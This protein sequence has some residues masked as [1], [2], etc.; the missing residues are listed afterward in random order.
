MVRHRYLATCPTGV[1]IYL[2]QE[3]AQL[4]A[5]AVVEMPAGV[6]FEGGLSLAYRVCLWSRLAN[7]VLLQLGTMQA[8]S[9]D[10]LY[11]A[12]SG[13]DWGAHIPPSGSLAVDFSGR[14]SGV[15]NE[16]FGAQ[17]L[18]DAIVDQFRTKGLSRPTV[19]L[20]APDVRV[21]ARLHKGA[22][23]LAIDLSGDSLHRRGYRLDGG[24]APLKENIAAAAL[25]AAGWSS[26]RAQDQALIDP[27]CGSSTLLLEGALMALDRAPGL[28]RERFGFNGWGGHDEGQWRAIFSEANERARAGAGTSVEIRGYDGDIQAVR[29]S[30]HNIQRLGLEQVV[31]IRCKDL[32]SLKRPTHRAL[33]SGLLAVNPPWGE[34]MGDVSHLPRLY[35]A[36]GEVMKREFDGW[37][38]LILTSDLSLGKAVGLQASHRHRFHNGRLELHCL[39]FDLHE[40]NHF[41]PLDQ[42]P[43][44]SIESTGQK[45]VTEGEKMVA[46]RLRKNLRRLRPWLEREGA[47]CFRLYDADIPEYAAAVDVYEDQIHVAEYAPPK[48]IAAEKAALRLDELIEATRVVMDIPAS[49][50]I[51]VKRRQRQR[52][53]DQY[54]RLGH[55]SERLV[56]HEGRIKVL[57]N[58]HDYLDTGLFLDHRPLRC[59]I[60]EEARGGHFLNLF[61]YTGVATLHAAAG[62]AKTSTSVD[63]SGTYLEW[64]KAN[65]ALNGFSERQHRSVRSD[66]RTWLETETR[67][68]DVIM[69]D[70]PS[71]S[72]SKGQSDFDVQADQMQLLTLAMARLSAGGVLYFSTN[73]RRF[74]LDDRVQQRWHV[75]DVSRAS[76]PPDFERNQRIHACWRLT[77]YA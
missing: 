40:T 22:L 53:A 3:L 59:W 44:T 42:P 14:S 35:N 72:N 75:T 48:E 68:Y 43:A 32:A 64:F 60:A 12:A 20:K 76:I 41:R 70:P 49:Q 31:R 5:E 39:Q 54:Q 46:N 8:D 55:A 15:R 74:K 47:T 11:E 73:R 25:W 27:M 18:K 17:R 34:R 67:L 36:L 9:A 23:S 77:H 57:V 63:A 61:S 52:G 38:S 56:V 51:A 2:A 50:S 10:S 58:L 69:L 6:S 37:Q 71:F 21:H 24:L 66:V 1:G 16:Q 33:S 45:V 4:G 26:E 13:V 7:R 19:D 62:G 28:T 65:L 29:R 30:Q